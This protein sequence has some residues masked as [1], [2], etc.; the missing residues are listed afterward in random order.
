MKTIYNQHHHQH[1]QHQ[2]QHYQQQ[3][4]QHIHSFHRRAITGAIN[5]SAA[6]QR[7]SQAIVSL[8]MGTTSGNTST[9]LANKSRTCGAKRHNSLDYTRTQCTY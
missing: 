3:H 4:Y 5:T 8:V 6:T 9:E 2:H 7:P 1:H